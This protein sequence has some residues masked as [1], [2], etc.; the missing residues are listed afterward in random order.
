MLVANDLVG[1]VIDTRHVPLAAGVHVTG[2]VDDVGARLVRR[3]AVDRLLKER[4]VQFGVHLDFED[5]LSD[6]GE[7]EGVEL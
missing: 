1:E 2:A 3:R 5:E 4:H 7:V 6:V